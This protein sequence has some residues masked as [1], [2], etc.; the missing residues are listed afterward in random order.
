M[1]DF[2][3]AEL[4]KSHKNYDELK[5]DIVFINDKYQVNVNIN[6]EKG[7]DG[8]VWLSIKRFDKLAIHDW[9]ELQIIKNKICGEEREAV[10]IYPAESRLV[11]SSNQ[12]HLWVL[13]K[14][15]KVPFGYKDR[16]VVGGHNIDKFVSGE[17]RQR[18]FNPDEK[19]SDCIS[20]EEAKKLVEK[21]K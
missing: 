21:K 8:L 6:K 17:S 11:D 3:R 12:F 7:F 18:P 2:T 9:R 13:P 16:L 14:G 10:E 5:N 4:D 1:K 19:P 20:I 15:D